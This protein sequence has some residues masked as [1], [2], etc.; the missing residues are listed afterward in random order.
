MAEPA[1]KA[2]K[3]T[4]VA[5]EVEEIQEAVDYVKS[6]AANTP[7]IGIICGSGLGGLAELVQDQV[8]IS[9]E[10]IPNFPVSTVPGHA[11]KLVLGTLGGT[12]VVVMKG[13]MHSYEGYGFR[14][15]AL[16][17][18]T[19]C[20]LG[21][22]VLFVTNAA[23]GLDASFNVGDL[24][25][26]TDHLNFPG[27]AC[28]NPLVG[29]HDPSFG[30]RFVPMSKPYDKKLRDTASQV[31]DELGFSAFMR[32]GVYAMLGGPTYETPAEC[33][34]MKT[35]GANAVGMSTVPEVIVAIQQGVKCFAMSLI[36]NKSVLDID[37][38][39]EPNHEEVLEAAAARQPDVQNLFV[40]LSERVGKMI[41]DGEF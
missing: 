36:T 40:N 29:P 33:R 27:F 18:R 37:D 21:I 2:A 11:G 14:R 13:R 7:A 24:M 17:I 31:A 20:N 30:A 32:K 19:L 39:N 3:T 9:Y 12:Q 23:G 34:F 16:P 22:K 25:I 5:K 8:V 41:A 10:D 6:K 28:Q 15:I 26:L 38:D 4:G 35:A 1:A